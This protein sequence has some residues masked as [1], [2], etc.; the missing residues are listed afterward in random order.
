MTGDDSPGVTHSFNFSFFSGTTTTDDDDANAA[1][2][3][4]FLLQYKRLLTKLSFVTYPI[5]R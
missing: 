2:V 4:L 3:Q 5:T 1:T